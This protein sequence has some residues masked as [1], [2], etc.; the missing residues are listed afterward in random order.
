MLHLLPNKSFLSVLKL[1]K[2]NIHSEATTQYI[3]CPSATPFIEASGWKNWNTQENV[4]R[5]LMKWS[6]NGYFPAGEVVE[7]DCHAA[8]RA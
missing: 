1:Y 4:S 3:F 5:F 6:R 2:S 8:H 7:R